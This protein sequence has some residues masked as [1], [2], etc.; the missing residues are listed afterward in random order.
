MYKIN[1]FKDI[2]N[3]RLNEE[4]QKRRE[5]VERWRQ[6]R[7]K[8]DDISISTT[9]ASVPLSNPVQT[10]S[11][12]KDDDDEGDEKIYDKD[13]QNTVNETEGNKKTDSSD[14]DN[15]AD[16]EVDPLDAYMSEI[17]KVANPTQQV[18][19]FYLFF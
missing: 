7:R 15:T 3:E 1:F 4:M 16:D 9:N 12:D 19:T 5:K 14:L 17:N 6:Q 13:N 8:T 18:Y 10:W 11:L 2:V